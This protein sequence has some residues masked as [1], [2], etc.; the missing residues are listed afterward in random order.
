MMGVIIGTVVSFPLGVYA[1][2]LMYWGRAQVPGRH[3]LTR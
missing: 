2:T 3:R 1:G